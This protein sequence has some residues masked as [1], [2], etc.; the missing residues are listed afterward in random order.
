MSRRIVIAGASGLIGTAV[1]EALEARGDTVI[2]LVRE[3]SSS[4]DGSDIAW[5]PKTGILDPDALRGADAVIV[6]NGV[7]IGEKRWN[8][9]RKALILSSRIDAVGTVAHLMATMDSPPPA[10]VSA[11]AMGIYG[12]RGD[13]ILNESEP[14]GEGY[15]AEVCAAWEQAAEPARQAGI[16]V[17]TS[18][19]GLVLSARG[20]ALAPMRP[21]FKLGLGGRIGDGKQWWSWISEVDVVR[22]FLHCID[23]EVRGPVNVASP[24]PVTNAEFT[25]ALGKALHRPT[26]LPTPRLGLNI[27]LGAELAEAVGYVSHRLQPAALLASGFTFTHQTIEEALAAVYGS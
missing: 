14:P 11:S 5:D 1:A 27:R 7:P 25:K 6:L 8:D 12:D 24:H 20:G 21:L 3:A 13:D 22:A 4:R 2:R 15:F 9:E 19:T 23:T 16:R 17:V 18:R 10:L 26:I